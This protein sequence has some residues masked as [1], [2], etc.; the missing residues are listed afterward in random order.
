MDVC[1]GQHHIYCGQHCCPQHALVPHTGYVYLPTLYMHNYP[2]HI[3]HIMSSTLYIVSPTTCSVTHCINCVTHSMSPT[4]C[5][6]QYIAVTFTTYN[7][8]HICLH[9]LWVHGVDDITYDVDDMLSTTCM[10]S[11]HYIRVIHKVYILWVTF[12]VFVNCTHNIHPHD[13]NV[14]T[15]CIHNI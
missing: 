5:D 14:S 9:T 6:P 8:Q 13:K 10:C 4:L 3:T 1:C 7:P 15:T 12:I 11:P 2:Q